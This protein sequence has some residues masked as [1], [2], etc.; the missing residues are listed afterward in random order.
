MKKLSLLYTAGLAALAIFTTSCSDDDTTEITAAGPSINFVAASEVNETVNLTDT[1]S[2]QLI[3]AKGDKN[4]D[5]LTFR[6]NAAGLAEGRILVDGEALDIAST[7]SIPNSEDAGATYAI[8]IVANTVFGTEN[9][10]I[11][12]SDNDGLTSSVSVSLTTEEVVTTTDLAAA[13]DFTFTRV[14]GADATGLDAFGLAWTSNSTASKAVVK[15]D[16]DKL[17]ILTAAEWT[18]IVT[19]EDL[20]AAVEAGTDVAEYTG[21]STDASATYS[22]VIATQVGSTYYILNVASAT[23]TSATAGTT[24]EIEGTF[25]QTAQAVTASR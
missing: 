17:V 16:A 5:E 15:K 19:E 24:V 3:T 25:K 22:D 10:Q 4:M 8:Q 14:G 23:V 2:F 11:A 21:V 13:T 1:I 20:I 12:V 18:S 9:I 6:V 7:Y